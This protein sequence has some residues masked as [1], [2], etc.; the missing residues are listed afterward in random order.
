MD[1]LLPVE[2]FRDW[3]ESFLPNHAGFPHEPQTCPLASWVRARSWA[4]ARVAHGRIQPHPSDPWEPLPSWA[5]RFEAACLDACAPGES[6]PAVVALRLLDRVAGEPRRP[7]TDGVELLHRL[8]VDGDPEMQ[9]LL[10]QERA[11]RKEILDA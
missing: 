2:R 1:E 7:T 6:I 8:F 11:K 4:L 10:E 3:L 5:A 9:A